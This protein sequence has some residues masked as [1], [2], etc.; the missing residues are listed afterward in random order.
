MFQKSKNFITFFILF[1]FIVITALQIIFTQYLVDS[2]YRNAL[3]KEYQHARDVLHTYFDIIKGEL[4]RVHQG[5]TYWTV[6]S[7]TVNQLP[8]GEPLPEDLLQSWSSGNEGFNSVALIIKDGVIVAGV[9]TE[10]DFWTK[11]MKPEQWE[12]T[13]SQFRDDNSLSKAVFLVKQGRALLVMG[14]PSCDDAGNISGKALHLFGQEINQDR[15]DV[16]SHLSGGTFVNQDGLFNISSVDESEPYLLTYL[17]QIDAQPYYSLSFGSIGIQALL[18]IVIMTVL[19]VMIHNRTKKLLQSQEKTSSL[20]KSHE[21][22]I[23]TISL[24][25]QDT[26]NVNHYSAKMEEL[27]QLFLSLTE[28]SHQVI[29]NSAV[30]L[31]Q[32]DD[33]TDEIKKTENRI[34]SISDHIHQTSANIKNSAS[35]AREMLGV[36]KILHE[37]VIQF[38]DVANELNQNALEGLVSIRENLTQ[39]NAVGKSSQRV[40]EILQVI[41]DI[42]DRTHLLAINAAIE[43]S[44]AGTHGKGFSV[45]ATEIRTLSETVASNTREIE[46][47]VRDIF[48]KINQA[49]SS[50]QVLGTIFDTIADRSEENLQFVESIN[51]LMQQQTS[52]SSQLVAQNNLMGSVIEEL[53]TAIKQ[54]LVGLERIQVFLSQ[55]CEVADENAQAVQKV[56]A[57]NQEI[58][59]LLH[60]NKKVYERLISQ[61]QIIIENLDQA[62]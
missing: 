50:T 37:K 27:E 49:V 17:P 29:K 21:Q 57:G 34:H 4:A 54:N 13:F 36:V 2:L 53:G 35:Q 51:S 41:N 42:S 28:H 6:V 32:V 47:V 7:D 8:T 39:I 40:L 48:Q 5:Y 58:L 56:D 24:S 26:D 55:L 59:Q 52:F 20:Q 18:N 43:A 22:T 16:L 15:L 31:G 33:V 62:H 11:V 10:V 61:I 14:S 60:S 19:M 44:R 12:R 9:G 30:L 1:V 38:E 45:V 25:Q 46:Q 3:E 23:Q